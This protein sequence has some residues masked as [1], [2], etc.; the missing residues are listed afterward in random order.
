[1]FET[2]KL[3]YDDPSAM[4]TEAEILEMRASGTNTDIILD[5][6]VCYPEGGGQPCDLGR[7]AA[8]LSSTRSR[9][10][11]RSSIP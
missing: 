1:M 6:T 9:K 7:L 5:R 10:G 11:R 3:Y 2:R 4:A 8:Y